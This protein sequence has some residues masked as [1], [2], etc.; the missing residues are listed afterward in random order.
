MILT[1]PVLP[2]AEY[3]INYDY[4]S[5]KLCVNKEKPKLQ[6]NGKCQLM[7]KLAAASESEKPISSDKKANPLEHHD[8][9]DDVKTVAVPGK[10][11]GLKTKASTLY[12]NFYRNLRGHAVFHP[13]T[14]IS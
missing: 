3:V 5:T 10:I 2:V 4:I 1:K 9:I 7:K 13:P 6:C 8:W 12:H 11:L 14:V